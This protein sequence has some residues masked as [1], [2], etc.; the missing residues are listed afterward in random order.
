MG[1][2]ASTGHRSGPTATS[3][4]SEAGRKTEEEL[5]ATF[6][7]VV[8]CRCGVCSLFC[9]NLRADLTTVHVPQRKTELHWPR[10]V[11][12]CIRPEA[13]TI[14]DATTQVACVLISC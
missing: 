7:C 10:S 13:L 3:T 8:R 2:G 1:A 9:V 14:L 6:T 5:R 4:T 11:L 12:L